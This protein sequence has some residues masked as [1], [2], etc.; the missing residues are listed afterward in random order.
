MAATSQPGPTRRSAVRLWRPRRALST[1]EHEVPDTAALN[2]V[3]AGAT[4]AVMRAI[5][6]AVRAAE[7]FDG[8][9]G[10]FPAYGDL[11]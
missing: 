3:L 5:V 4:D 2:A 1:E 7:G 9:G 8:P 6:K 11:Y 10:V